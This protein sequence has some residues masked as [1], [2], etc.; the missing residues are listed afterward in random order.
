MLIN[1]MLGAVPFAWRS[2]IRRIPGVA[3]AQRAI[4]AAAM[5]GREFVHEVDAGPARGMRLL[6]KM[7]ED[8]GIWTG[9]YEAEFAAAVAAAVEPGMV[10][11]DIG[12]W[13][14]FFAAIMSAHGAKCVHV[15]EPLPENG[16]RIERLGA[17]NPRFDIRLHACAVG[18]RD[19][20][21]DLSVMPQSSMAKIAGSAFQPDAPQDRRL[22][23][24]LA[25]LD[26]LVVSGE[27]APPD[28]VKIDVEGAEALVL[29]GAANVLKRHAPIVFAEV[30]TPALLAECGSLL[31]EAGYRV[32]LIGP[33]FGAAGG[34]PVHIRATQRGA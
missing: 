3:E 23:V 33:G 17:L 2:R 26:S 32:A 22:N 1:R 21:I 9:T 14:G 27:V 12:G 30:H 8:K 13:H 24:R 18:D 7:P 28:I 15:F 5:D 25:S 11:C 6:V 4:V 19:G 34:D 29:R 31:S 16:E 10:A 20:R